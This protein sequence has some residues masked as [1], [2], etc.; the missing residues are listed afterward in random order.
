MIV[1]YFG[2]PG[3]GK[4]TFASMLAIKLVKKGKTVF[5]NFPVL[6][7]GIFKLDTSLIGKVQIDSATLIIDE[8]GLVW[9]NRD[10][11]SFGRDTLSWFKLHRHYK[12]DVIL[13]SQA[14]NDMDKKIRD[15]SDHYYNIKK[16]LWFSN[17]REYRKRVGID[18]LTH[19]IVDEYYKVGIFSGGLK[20]CFRP[21]WYKYF[22]S[23]SAPQLPGAVV[24]IPYVEKELENPAD[25]C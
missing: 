22:D 24:M 17:A 6:Y 15:L 25:P 7:P 5:T 23:Y 13:L 18:E 21:R 1:T 2:S 8:S 3:M 11:K 16:L 12:C 14:W 10:F 19:D 9:G 4:T 20:V